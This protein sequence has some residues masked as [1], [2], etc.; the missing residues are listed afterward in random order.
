M[1]LTNNIENEIDVI[2]DRIYE[3]IK[4]MTSSEETAYFN[5]IADEARKMHGFRVVKS[6][7]GDT[8]D[9]PEYQV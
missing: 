2:R 7:I 3:K 6:A 8:I 5:A 4:N 1:K 9:T